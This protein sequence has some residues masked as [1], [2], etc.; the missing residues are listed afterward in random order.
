MVQTT[1][2]LMVGDNPPIRVSEASPRAT[3]MGL[4]TI[5][6]LPVPSSTVLISKRYCS[7]SSL[8]LSPS[9]PL[10]MS[11]MRAC[12]SLA[13]SSASLSAFLLFLPSSLTP[14]FSLLSSTHR[15]R[16][17]LGIS[18]R[19]HFSS[20]ALSPSSLLFSSSPLSPPSVR[21]RYNFSPLS[22][23]LQREMPISVSKYFSLPSLTSC[24]PLSPLQILMH[25][26]LTLL[27][28]SL[29]H[30]SISFL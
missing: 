19:N 2:D 22:F 15:H 4:S 12:S 21:F 17:L 11:Q 29:K 25:A 10:V 3:F 8:T 20:T 28:P 14:P 30:L 16:R 5:F 24:A 6:I 18:S 7:T 13:K 23:V 26:C 9:S 1:P 27:V